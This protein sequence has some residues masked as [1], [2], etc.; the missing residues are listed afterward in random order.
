VGHIQPATCV[1]MAFKLTVVCT[2]SNGWK[3]SK[4]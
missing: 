2:F 3:Q 1:C 4:E